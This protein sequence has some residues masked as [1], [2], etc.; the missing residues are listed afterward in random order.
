MNFIF[1]YSMESF[2]LFVTPTFS[3]KPKKRT[4]SYPFKKL[5]FILF[6]I[7]N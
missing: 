1:G 6:R 7:N 4:L 2:F 5:V 3:M